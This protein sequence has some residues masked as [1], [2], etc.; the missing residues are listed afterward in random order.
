MDRHY[1]KIDLKKLISITRSYGDQRI[2]ND[3][4]RSGIKT[5][6]EHVISGNRS[7][8]QDTSKFQSGFLNTVSSLF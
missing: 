2:L 3:F 5:I 8:F 1:L 7:F 6:L 4:Q